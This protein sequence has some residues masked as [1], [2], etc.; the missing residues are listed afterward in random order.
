MVIHLI[1]VNSKEGSVLQKWL[2]NGFL[3][4]ASHSGHG[5]NYEGLGRV[6][7]VLPSVGMLAGFASSWDNAGNSFDVVCPKRRRR[8]LEA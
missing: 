2:E 8:W 1:D 3:T 7:T 6:M 4:E 5:G